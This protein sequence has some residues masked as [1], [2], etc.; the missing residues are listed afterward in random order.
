MMGRLNQQLLNAAYNGDQ[1]EIK[2]L[3][4]QGA[5]QDVND[6]GLTALMYT[7]THH[8]INMLSLFLATGVDT[9]TTDSNG[10]TAL[11][12]AARDG[13]IKAL[14]ILL[15]ARADIDAQDDKGNTALIIA[16][17]KE[18]TEIIK[19]LL[20]NHV[21]TEVKT[22]CGNT[23]LLVAVQFELVDIIRILLDAGAKTETRNK[24][25]TTALIRSVDC[26]NPEVMKILLAAGAKTEARDRQGDTALMYAVIA[27]KT[28]II[29]MLL[30]AKANKE[31]S[32]KYV[33]GSKK[34]EDLISLLE[35]FGTFQGRLNDINYKEPI[36][37]RFTCPISLQIMDDPVCL[38]TGID[39]ERKSLE[40]W[41]KHCEDMATTTICPVSKK[42][43]SPEELNNC[44]NFAFKECIEEFVAE[45]EEK[46]INTQNAVAEQEIEGIKTQEAVS[47]RRLH[48]KSVHGLFAPRS[49]NNHS[50]AANIAASTNWVLEDIDSPNQRH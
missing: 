27:G 41:F 16:V 36:K 44:T 18:Q 47:G 45:Q 13:N 3:L 25:G 22:Q 42:A 9:D 32:L 37:A 7:V 26:T 48:A 1:A 30:K 40:A 33:H 50:V 43:V 20:D 2:R 39:Y 19:Q 12:L 17:Q 28:D 15:N 8:R 35:N 5:E 11:M 6:E 29:R 31:E 21:N 10:R 14:R 49:P 4:N 34:N 46:Y 23:A 38:S 24:N